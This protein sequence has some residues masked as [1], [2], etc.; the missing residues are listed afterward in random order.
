MNELIIIDILERF[1]SIVLWV[2][3]P[4]LFANMIVGIL[5]G[6]IQ[7]ATQVQ[8]G[9]LSFF[10][11]LMVLVFGIF[12][13]GRVTTDVFVVYTQYTFTKLSYLSKGHY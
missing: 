11:K 3:I 5:V 8:E 6:I 13:F 2:C 12:L 10:P 7:T 4:M 9:T 1:F